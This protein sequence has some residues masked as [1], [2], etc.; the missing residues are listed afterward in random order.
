MTDQTLSTPAA[1]CSLR[2]IRLRHG[3]LNISADLT[4]GSF[5]YVKTVLSYQNKLNE[6]ATSFDFRTDLITDRKSTVRLQISLNL[7][8]LLLK[9]L[10]WHVYIILEDPAS[11]ELAEIPVHMDTRQRLFHKFLYNGAH[12]TENGFSFYP[13]YTGDKTLAFAYRE[14]TPYDSTSLIYK[15]IFAVLL[16]RL[17]RSYWKKQ[18]ICLVCEKFSSMAQDN[19]Y[20]FFGGLG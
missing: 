8:D 2:S 1:S 17:T 18:H 3:N 4:A 15:E 7:K 5:K 9:S 13:F 10:Y 6:D 19:G 20:Y 14:C 11:G 12:H 16:Y